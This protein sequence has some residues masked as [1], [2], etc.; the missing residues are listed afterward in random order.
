[1]SFFLTFVIMFVFWLLLS[2]KFYPLFLFMGVI[3]SLLVA[4]AYHHFFLGNTSQ[5][6]LRLAWRRLW[7]FFFYLPWLL[8]QILLANI[9]IAYLILHPRMPIDPV[10]IK[11]KSKLDQNLAYVIFAN[12]ITLTPGTITVECQD[13]EYL[14]H[15][16]DRFSA[17]GLL[18]GEMEGKVAQIF[19]VEK[20]D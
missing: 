4:Y 17:E 3:S 9:H 16:L 1:M 10:L 13:G 12:S 8:Y 18:A 2:G 6:G 14:I 19:R 7:R 11:F 20:G 5:V 15:A